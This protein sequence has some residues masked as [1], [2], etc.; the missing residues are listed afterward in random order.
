VYGLDFLRGDALA[1]L[2]RP[3]E[4]E[5]AYRR[6]TA[7]FPDHLQAYA[8]L[9]VLAFVQ[10][11][12]AEVQEVLEAMARANPGPAANRLAAKTWEAFGDRKAAAAWRSRK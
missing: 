4:A 3:A 1:R 11:R 10:G 9:A 8:N 12:R 2:A 6:E 5:A 7:A